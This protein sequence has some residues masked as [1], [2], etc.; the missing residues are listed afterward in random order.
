[1]S[2]GAGSGGRGGEAG[3]GGRGG[4]FEAGGEGVAGG[5]RA[6]TGADAGKIVGVGESPDIPLSKVSGRLAKHLLTHSFSRTI[7][8]VSVS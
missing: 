4:E 7:N 5:A 6:G 2:G 3:V 1:M 8:A